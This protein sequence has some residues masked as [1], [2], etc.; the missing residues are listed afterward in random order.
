MSC[1]RDGQL[2]RLGGSCRRALVTRPTGKELILKE[3]L[4]GIPNEGTP[5]D[6]LRTALEEARGLGFEYG[7]RAEEKDADEPKMKKS[8][9]AAAEGQK[10]IL[11]LRLPRVLDRVSALRKALRVQKKKAE[12]QLSK[13]KL[14][15]TPPYPID[16]SRWILAGLALDLPFVILT[17][18]LMTFSALG[19]FPDFATGGALQWSV[20]IFFAILLALIVLG[21]AAPL[22]YVIGKPGHRRDGTGPHRKVWWTMC[23]FAGLGV[24]LILV[25]PFLLADAREHNLGIVADLTG[26]LGLEDPALAWAV[27]FQLAGLLTGL[28]GATLFLLGTEHRSHAKHTEKLEAA[29]V[30]IEEL[31]KTERAWLEIEIAATEY[32]ISEFF[33]FR[34]RGA[35][36]AGRLQNLPLIEVKPL[37]RK[38]WVDLYYEMAE[39]RKEEEQDEGRQDIG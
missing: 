30:G 31:P 25:I 3:H 11:H 38:H 12:D 21:T 14:V 19:A 15:G 6:S 39:P 8:H 16:K 37:D 1:S 22:A 10:R 35:A 33:R 32:R 29:D 9:E 20:A 18:S 34:E 5:D 13:I 26:R 4:T 17:E 36:E 2:T 24:A 27:A 28:A 23:A 7:A